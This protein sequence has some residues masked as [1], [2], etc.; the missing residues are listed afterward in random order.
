[1]ESVQIGLT[2]GVKY[3][4]HVFCMTLRGVVP[5]MIKDGSY[6]YEKGSK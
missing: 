3:Y 5:R 6:V 2:H 4:K 1:M